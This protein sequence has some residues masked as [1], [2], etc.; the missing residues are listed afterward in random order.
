MFVGEGEC[1][2]LL[3]HHLDPSPNYTLIIIK[4]RKERGPKRT[5]EEMKGRNYHWYHT[6]VK[7]IRRDYKQL[8]ANKLANLEMDKFLETY[9][10]PRL[11]QEEIDNLNIRSLVAKL[12]V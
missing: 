12:N 8:Y 2:L 5:K 9:N 1:N 7:K 3:L 6:D 11:N 10:L 4:R